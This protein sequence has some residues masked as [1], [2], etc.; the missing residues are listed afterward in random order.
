MSTEKCFFDIIIV[1]LG[2]VGALLAN[3]LGK[4]NFNVL[5]LEQK[6]EI[7]P[8]PRAIHFDGEVM[9]IFQNAGLASEVKKIARPS[10]KG[11]HFI[12]S[13]N[14]TLFVRKG[15]DGLGDQCWENSWYFF[16][17]DLE[18]VL[19][20]GI[21]RYPN[22]NVKLGEMVSDID[23]QGS[24]ISV[25]ASSSKGDKNDYQGRYL[26]GCDGARSIVSKELPAEIEDLGL[27]EQWLVID[28]KGEDSSIRFKTLPDHTIQHCDPERPMTR[29]YISSSRRRWEIMVMPDDDIEEIVNEECIWPI[30]SPWIKPE[31][32]TIERVQIYTFHSIIRDSW[33]KDNIILVGD[34]A[35][36]SP[37]F[38]GQ[39]LC[40]GIRDASALAW[41]LGLLL[42]GKLTPDSIVAYAEERKSHVREYIDLAVKCGKTIKT[43]DPQLITSY[44]EQKTTNQNNVFAFPKPQLGSGD[45]MQGPSPL[46]QISPQFVM[47]SGG[48][49]DDEALYR[50]ILIIKSNLGVKDDKALNKIIKDWKIKVIVENKSANKW[51]DS[52]NVE[53]VLIRPDRYVYGLAS[54]LE[55]IYDVLEHFDQSMKKFKPTV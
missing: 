43:G 53:A 48:L 32:A 39:G 3:L 41:R 35:H 11:M 27:D 4:F 2:P 6:K 12:G 9:R 38:L 31:D 15:V 5:V 8:S 1:G 25:S 18:K 30:L 17:P 14:E 46:G 21:T 54:K 10:H 40:A 29:C 13:K 23:N 16:Q 28:L 52:F 20:G 33:I 26:I 19:R 7:H 50:F 55:N 37:P 45:W 34:S 22:I 42:E 36:Q 44:F 24:T 51:L 47:D 49:S